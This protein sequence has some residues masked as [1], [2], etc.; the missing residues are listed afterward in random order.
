MKQS[1]PLLSVKCALDESAAK[2]TVYTHC[3]EQIDARSYRLQCCK[4]TM[5][6]PGFA[7]VHQRLHERTFT[8]YFTSRLHV[9]HQNPLVPLVNNLEC[10]KTIRIKCLFSFHF[11]ISQLPSL[12]FS[13]LSIN[14]IFFH[15]FV[16]GKLPSG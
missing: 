8:F 12:R 1:I 14:R 3:L 6:Y 13:S 11:Q 7:C 15:P 16:S 4:D 5:F 10:F 9:L 2:E